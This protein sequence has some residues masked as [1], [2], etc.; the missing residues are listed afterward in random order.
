[1]DARQFFYL[2]SEMRNKQKEYFKT[3]T[4]SALK[5]SKALEKRVD[6]EIKR[7]GEV[8]K[9]KQEPRLSGF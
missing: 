6:G 9:E 1:M 8:L 2:V 7:V 4:Q 5:E 3:R